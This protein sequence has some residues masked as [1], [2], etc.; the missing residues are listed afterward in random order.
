MKSLVSIITP[1][2]NSEPSI[3]ET[4]ESVLQQT[5]KNWELILVDDGS[6]DLTVE[7]IQ[8]FISQ[9]PNIRLLRGVKNQGAAWARNKGIEVAKGAYVAFL[10]ADDL[11]KPEK[12]EVQLA[13]M[14]REACEVCFS[15]YNL[16]DDS[17][18]PLNRQIKALA[19]L[20]YDKLLKSNYIGNSTGVYSVKALGKITAPNLRKRQDWLLWLRAIKASGKPAKGVQESLVYYRVRKNSLSSNK[21]KLIK[22]NYW[23]YRKGL[24]FSIIKSLRYMVGFFIEYFFIKP[25]QT[26]FIDET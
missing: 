4:I 21:F 25:K 19:I 24:R 9:N 7:K 6:T 26:F 17:G 1:T 18:T 11:W 10:D 23:V 5:H 20:N 8:T 14:H 15:S 12:L 22:Y 2:F 13:F 16:I 3:S